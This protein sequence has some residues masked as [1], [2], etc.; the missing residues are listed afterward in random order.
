MKLRALKRSANQ[1]GFTLIELMIVVAIIGILAAIA[2]P[3]F[4]RYQLKAKT[5]EAKTNIGAIKTSQEAWKAEN[6]FYA[7]CVANPAGVT[8]T[9]A[10]QAWVVGAAGTGWPE[11]GYQP[12]S[13]VYYQYQVATGG[14]ASAA[15]IGA[16]AAGSAGTD[17]AIGAVSDLD[18]DASNGEFGYATDAGNTGAPVVTTANNA[19][20]I[21]TIGTVEDLTP[22]VF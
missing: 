1:K 9:G 19:T 12:S 4:L 16:I 21:T 8:A 5:A 7:N 11:I 17:M 2:I 20:A 13:N 10:K 18:Q 22:G 14:T 6:D 15:A 3:N